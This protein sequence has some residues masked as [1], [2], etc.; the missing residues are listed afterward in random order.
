MVVGHPSSAWVSTD[1]AGVPHGGSFGNVARFEQAI[2]KVG[3]NLAW[4][5]IWDC[6]YIYTKRGH[7]N[8][9]QL[10]C[11]DHMKD[12]ALPL[13]QSL[14]SY[15]LEQWNKFSKHTGETLLMS[16]R[17]AEKKRYDDKRKKVRKEYEA[18]RKPVL[19]MAFPSHKVISLPSS[20][21]ICCG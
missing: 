8:V 1:S 9:T 18:M 15:M 13:T 19:D 17:R 4:S 16:L 2:N 14:L 6:F 5:R 11:W 10:Q 3:L 7:T 20:G 12:C 21:R